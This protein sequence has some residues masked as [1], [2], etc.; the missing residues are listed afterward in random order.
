[1]NRRMVIFRNKIAFF[2]FKIFLTVLWNE[3]DYETILW[4]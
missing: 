2:F 3:I 4:E 1:M